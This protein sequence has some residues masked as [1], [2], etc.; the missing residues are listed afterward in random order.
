MAPDPTPADRDC[1]ILTKI[2]G[3]TLAV[4]RYKSK[5]I[6]RTRGTVDAHA[7]D[8]GHEIDGLLVKYP[9]ILQFITM[10]ET[11]DVTLLFEW[12]SPLQR[13]VLD[14]GP[15][16]ALT[17]IGATYH[18]HFYDL[19]KPLLWTQEDLDVLGRLIGVPRPE[20]HS[21]KSIEDMVAAVQAFQDKEGVCI[22]FNGGQS[23]KKLKALRYLMIHR[24][25]SE[26]GSISK[27]LDLWFAQ[28]RPAAAPFYDYIA[29][30]LDHEL[31]VQADPDIL[32]I[33]ATDFWVH[34]RVQTLRDI[35][36]HWREKPR[37]EAAAYIIGRWGSGP[38]KGVAFACGLDNRELTDREWRNLMDIY[39][40]PGVKEA[41]A[42][43]LGGLIV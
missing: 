27:L 2:D 3:S 40:E 16:P 14:Y 19:S 20:H 17:L 36:K 31:A 25:K 24:A 6:T 28:G 12:T 33:V 15:E 5:L 22:Y 32:R 4:S 21:F 8:S 11:M 39:V 9:G 26:I 38:W 35:L 43:R 30:T 42:E 1:E 37:R 13:I 7:L 29:T 23:I 34:L 18:D 10:K 41:E